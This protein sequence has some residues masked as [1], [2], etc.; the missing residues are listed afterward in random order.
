MATT[1][2]RIRTAKTVRINKPKRRLKYIVRGSSTSQ[3]AQE[4]FAS[5][6]AYIGAISKIYYQE[7]NDIEKFVGFESKQ[8]ATL[9]E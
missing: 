7:E 1:P 5:S 9:A 6:R 2:K 8:K 4:G 3:N